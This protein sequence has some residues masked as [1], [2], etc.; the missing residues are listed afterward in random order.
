MRT[1]NEVVIEWRIGADSPLDEG[2]GNQLEVE[3]RRGGVGGGR[4]DN[5]A[6]L[7][8]YDIKREVGER[9][10]QVGAVQ[11][12]AAR[13]RHHRHDRAPSVAIVSVPRIPED[14]P[15]GTVLRRPTA[16]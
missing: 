10:Q 11:R 4:V 6:F 9:R 14:V 2:G 8:M 15:A 7:T 3:G 16:V 5:S 13:Y 1:K 12:P